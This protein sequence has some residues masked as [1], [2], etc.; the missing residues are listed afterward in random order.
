MQKWI[1]SIVGLLVMTSGSVYAGQ[2]KPA[3]KERPSQTSVASKTAFATIKASDPKVK[4]AKSATDLQASKALVGKSGA[5][6]GTV[7]KV[8][9]PKS[10]SVVLLNFAQD[11]KSALVGAVD[12]QNFA[13]LPDLTKLKG[14]KVLL[15]GKVVD[16]KGQPQVQID[17]PDDVRVIK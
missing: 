2:D 4:G 7:T 5:F 6:V 3:K 12:D 10:N 9:A 14:K 15:S 8:F 17:S 1:T 16:F 13:K 11:Y